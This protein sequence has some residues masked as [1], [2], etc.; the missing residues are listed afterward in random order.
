MFCDMVAFEGRQFLF[1]IVLQPCGVLWWCA[2]GFGPLPPTPPL[3]PAY[4]DPPF[5]FLFFFFFFF[6]FGFRESLP[7]HLISRRLSSCNSIVLGWILS[8]SLI[9]K[10]IIYTKLVP[11][12]Y[13]FVSLIYF[14]II[15]IYY[16]GKKMLL[17][18]FLWIF[19]SNS[20]FFCANT[21]Q[22]LLRIFLKI[23]IQNIREVLNIHPLSNLRNFEKKKKI[24]LLKLQF[25]GV[26]FYRII[27]FNNFMMYMR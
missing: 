9:H 17:Q 24:S 21:L 26:F 13:L 10:W 18:Y 27:Y 3:S 15:Y 8:L 4:S 16:I 1:L 2:V 20:N 6:F 22:C 7:S 11:F 25:S 23:N 5:L 12:I 14:F 19:I